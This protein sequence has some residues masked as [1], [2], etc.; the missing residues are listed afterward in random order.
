MADGSGARYPDGVRG[1]IALAVGIGLGLWAAVPV[2]ASTL[3]VESA[4][5]TQ[6]VFYRAGPGEANRVTASTDGATVTVVDPGAM[7]EPGMNC[8]SVGPHTAT[9]TR[10]GFVAINME[11]GARNDRGRISGPMITLRAEGGGGQDRLV[12]SQASDNFDGGRGADVVNGRGLSDWIRYIDRNEDLRVTLAD[13]KRNDG[14]RL[15]GAKRDRLRSIE[16]AVGGSG[17]DLLTGTAGENTLTGNAG[18]DVLRGRGGPDSFFEEDG[19][20]RS[21]GGS[22]GDLFYA[23]GAGRDRRYGGTGADTLQDAFD[24]GADLQVGGPG[25]DTAQYQGVNRITLDGQANDGNCAD[26]ACKSSAEGDNVQVE[27]LLVSSGDDVL[28]GSRRAEV[29]RP[30]GGADTV[31][32]RGGDDTINSHDDGAADH[33]DCGAG[34]DTIAGD[35]EIFDLTPNC[36]VFPP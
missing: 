25:L 20:D 12:G 16:N 6:E 4:G 22:G 21:Y 2:S 23:T 34:T 28:I 8:D 27:E 5:K 13:G 17:D 11:L 15:D 24:D 32:A 9:C 3:A 14:S 19:R 7:I 35:F 31:L 10:A 30:S 29:F 1:R 33:F 18:H 36:E 26:P